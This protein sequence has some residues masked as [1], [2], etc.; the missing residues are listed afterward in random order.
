[1]N[2]TAE[3]LKSLAE[4]ESFVFY[5]GDL[6]AEILSCNPTKTLDG[7][8]KFK[9]LLEEIFSTIRQLE[10][11]KKIIVKK[12]AVKIPVINKR[13]GKPTN[14]FLRYTEYSATGRQP[15]WESELE[16]KAPSIDGAFSA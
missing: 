10:H 2:I 12:E 6:G 16:L 7:A 3:K 5:R 1:M 9:A 4:G 8:P 14:E 13:T 11:D 15:I